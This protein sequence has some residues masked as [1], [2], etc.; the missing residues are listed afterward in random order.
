LKGQ[1]SRFFYRGVILRDLRVLYQGCRHLAV[2]R[3]QIDGEKE[4]GRETL[5]KETSG[6]R[7]PNKPDE[8]GQ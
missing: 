4:G 8:P 2:V 3:K 7:A 6:K 5:K 1:G